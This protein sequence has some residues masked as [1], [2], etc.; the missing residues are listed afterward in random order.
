[1]KCNQNCDCSNAI[2]HRI[3]RTQVVI[4]IIFAYDSPG[5]ALP[6]CSPTSYSFVM[7]LPNRLVSC[8]TVFDTVLDTDEYNLFI[9]SIA[10]LNHQIKN[11]TNTL[12]CS[13]CC[14]DASQRCSAYQFRHFHVSTVWRLEMNLQCHACAGV[15]R[16]FCRFQNKARRRENFLKIKFAGRV[17]RTTELDGVKM[18]NPTYL[19]IHFHTWPR[20]AY[21]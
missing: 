20:C 9:T 17:V 2:D 15:E 18:K 8:E 7:G 21:E 13:T 19:N 5:P 12:F 16:R 10:R 1:M 3:A 11:E 4:I 14:L 6:I